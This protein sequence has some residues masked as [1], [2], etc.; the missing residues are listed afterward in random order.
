M[1]NRLKENKFL[2]KNYDPTVVLNCAPKQ[3]EA[4]TFPLSQQAIQ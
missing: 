2:Q 1:E 4:R 3:W